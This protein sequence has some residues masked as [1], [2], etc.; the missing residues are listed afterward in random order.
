MA[1]EPKVPIM[2]GVS[3]K[4]VA[5]ARAAA[6]PTLYPSESARKDIGKDG[7]TYT[8]WTETGTVDQV[9]GESTKGGENKPKLAV[10]VVAVRFRPGEPNQNKLGW[11]RMMLHPDIVSGRPVSE[12]VKDSYEQMSERNLAALVSLLDVAG[13]MPADGS[14]PPALLQHLFPPKGGKS[15]LLGTKVSVKI[16]QQP[17]EGGSRDKQEAAEVFLPAKVVTP[18]PALPPGL[19]D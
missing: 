7:K 12:A 16:L 14:L 4:A 5:N 17:N 11:F 2:F 9:W 6:D 19:Q 1:A 10:F 15:P 18:D 8:R 13:K 3:A